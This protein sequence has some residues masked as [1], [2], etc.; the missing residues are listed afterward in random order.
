ML[1]KKEWISLYDC[2]YTK[3][4][5]LCDEYDNVTIQKILSFHKGGK[6]TQIRER[7]FV[8][9]RDNIRIDWEGKWH[10]IALHDACGCR[11]LG[12]IPI[13]ILMNLDHSTLVVMNKR[14]K[15]RTLC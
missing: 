5:I 13:G 6:Y 14:I 3:L 2:V 11:S 12:Y 7:L 1:P 15:R 9:I 4:S 8:W 10:F